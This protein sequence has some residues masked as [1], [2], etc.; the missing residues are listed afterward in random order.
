[1]PELGSRD[2]WEDVWEGCMGLWDVI[3]VGLGCDGC[4]V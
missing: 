1:M 4:E 2:A 3:V